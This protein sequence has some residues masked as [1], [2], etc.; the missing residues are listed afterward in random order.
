[1]KRCGGVDACRII[2]CGY[3]Q[4]KAEQVL[5]PLYDALGALP[6]GLPVNSID[7]FEGVLRFLSQLPENQVS[8][9]TIGCFDYE[10]F[11]VLLRF[12]VHMIRRRT[13]THIMKACECIESESSASSLTL[14]RQS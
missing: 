9:C 10:P 13:Q 1:V 4:H 14:V 2:A 12:P 8:Q 11:A 5:I 7:C 6:A 3:D